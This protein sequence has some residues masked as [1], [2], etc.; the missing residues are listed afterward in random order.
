[1]HKKM[2]YK[3]SL[4]DSEKKTRLTPPEGRKC[5]YLLCSQK[6]SKRKLN[7][8]RSLTGKLT[9]EFSEQFEQSET[10]KRQIYVVKSFLEVK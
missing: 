6:L 2:D 3:N 7:V 4:F 10:T 1:M 9:N 5:Q 8:F